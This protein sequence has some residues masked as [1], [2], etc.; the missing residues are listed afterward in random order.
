MQSFR[1]WQHSGS[2]AWLYRAAVETLLGLAVRPGALSL[3]PRLP[4]H[5]PSFEI[6]VK[7]QGHDLTL[8]WERDAHPATLVKP[9]LRLAWGDW[10]EL[11]RLP[12]KAV[13]LVRGQAPAGPAQGLSSPASPHPA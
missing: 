1:R 3:S 6:R 9:D 7:L 4:A 10:V 12:K 5:W 2:A 11:E 13:L 8:H